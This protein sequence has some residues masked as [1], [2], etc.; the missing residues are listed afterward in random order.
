M[1]KF[2]HR[3]PKN[4]KKDPV[5]SESLMYRPI[6]G[7]YDPYVYPHGTRP[8]AVILDMDGTLEDYLGRPLVQGM[9][10]ARRAH[11]EGH[12]LVI[13]TARHPGEYQRTHDWLVDNLG[14][15]F[16]GPICRASD[17]PRLASY[18]K[19]DLHDTLSAIY[20]FVGA[21]DDN[22]HVIAEWRTI[23]GFDVEHV[24][25]TGKVEGTGRYSDQYWDDNDSVFE[26]N[27]NP[28]TEPVPIDE[29][30]DELYHDEDWRKRPDRFSRSAHGVRGER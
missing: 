2:W 25:P 21:A 19:R 28:M 18:F 1:T 9:K 13:I 5:V 16:V 11:R 23:P 8:T 4:S 14:L 22:R 30:L 15:P 7:K 27:D 10:F 20:E 6:Y 24:N 3:H 26:D 29:I 17:D 12:I